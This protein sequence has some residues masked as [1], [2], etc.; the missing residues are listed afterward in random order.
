MKKQLLLSTIAIVLFT[1]AQAQT[2][3]IQL[4]ATGQTVSYHPG[5]DGDLQM[6]V[7][8]PANRFTDNG[9]GTIT[10]AFTGLMW[11]QD[12]NL[13]ASRDPD[14]DQDRTPGDGDINWRTALDYIQKLNDE[15]YLGHNDWRMPNLLELRS[16]IDLNYDSITFPENHPFINLKKIYWSST[17]SDRLRGSAKV[18]FLSKYY[19]HAN[20]TYPAGHWETIG[21]DLGPTISYY[22]IYLLPV[23]DG[24]TNGETDIPQSGQLRSYY[25]GDDA[26]VGDGTPWPSPRLV[27]NGDESVTDRLTGLM[28]TKNTDLMYA[29]DPDFDT[30]GDVQGYVDWVTAFGYINKLN[31]E[32]YLGHNDWRLPNRNELTSLIDYGR[33]APGI[34]K[35]HPFFTP[36]MNDT[37]AG[38]SYWSSSTLA[39]NPDEAWIYHFGVTNLYYHP[40][41]IERAVWPVRT[42]NSSLPTGS[43]NGYIDGEDTPKKGFEITLQGP[44]NARA[45]TDADGY[46][47]FSHIP[48]GSYLV[49]PSSEYFDISPKSKTVAVNGVAVNCDFTAAYNRAY[50]WTDISSHLSPIDNAA[51]AGLSDIYFVSDNEG[52]ITSSQD[53]YH[54][55]DG[56]QTFE[57][58]ILPLEGDYT[59]AI[60]MFDENEGYAG[61]ASGVIY[62]TDN[63][64]EE[65]TLFGFTG[66]WIQGISFPPGSTTGYSIG[67]GGSFWEIRPDGLEQIEFNTQ[68]DQYCISTPSVGN[69]YIGGS[70]HRQWHYD[71]N[72]ITPDCMTNG[73]VNGIYYYNDTTGWI[74]QPYGGIVGLL[75]S[76][77]YSCWWLQKPDSEEY[78]YHLLDIH[79]PNGHD[80]WTVGTPG[81]IYY[82]PNGNDYYYDPGI[83]KYFNNT[84][85]H[86]QAKGL[87]NSYLQSVYFT[88][89][90]NGYASGSNGTLLK[91]SLLEGA[92]AGADI[93][94][95]K[96]PG[97]F[98]D[99]VVN[100]QQRTVSAEVADS[101]D[102]KNLVAELFLSAGA[103]V[104]PPGGSRQDFTNPVVY[105]VTASD[106]TSKNWT[107]TVTTVSGIEEEMPGSTEEGF[108]LFPNPAGNEFKVQSLPAGQAGLKFKVSQATLEIFDLNGKKLLEK[109]ITKGTKEFT[110]DVSSLNSGLY[111]C[112]IRTENGSVTKKLVIR[113]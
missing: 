26:S 73:G 20:I 12:A 98:G 86:Q 6:G 96:L 88:S 56:G 57:K 53:I 11:L 93:L 85:W 106:G 91:Y 19:L 7:P 45:E 99:A 48:D 47:E 51:G 21:K 103:T 112:R 109:Q 78:Q 60:F 108:V 42:D 74:V 67:T 68:L 13:I 24:G 95:I 104:D 79:T 76:G 43:I 52:W 100:K 50:G 41:S 22:V 81:M 102:I 27:D 37:P 66:A 38:Y 15:N 82:S 39:V 89:A 107:V 90:T 105:K 94:G 101:V 31:T 18:I 77:F 1:L 55:T 83:P 17:T 84:T 46:Y 65:W 33:H 34:P 111:F 32:N 58:Q 9:N 35:N 70:P 92:P 72:E 8:I 28:W 64:G 69:T 4:P 59:S 36:W 29:R 75:A 63:G 30:C 16:L 61:S 40:K 2:G 3:A 97:Q 71:G 49:T 54:T 62:H 113:K 14:F 10:D 23:R 44:V 25:A 80:V 110:V 5:D 87:T